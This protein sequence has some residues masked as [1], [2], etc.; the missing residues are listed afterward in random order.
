MS[1]KTL[2]TELD[3][4]SF[5]IQPKC[6]QCVHFKSYPFFKI[7][8][9]P[10]VCSSDIIGRREN[11]IA[12]EAFS[13]NTDFKGNTPAQSRA[14]RGLFKAMGVNLKV[15]GKTGKETRRI[16]LEAATYLI[17]VERSLM[18]GLVLGG[19]YKASNGME[20]DLVAFGNR[21][22]TLQLE[23]GRYLTVEEKNV[24]LIEV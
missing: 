15:K 9:S 8:S 17:A 21:T 13:I 12:C 23:D 19:Y 14:L 3:P 6:K 4:A 1:M 18:K 11:D 10:Q 20:G 22:V 24:E 5:G 7:N 2:L 16:L